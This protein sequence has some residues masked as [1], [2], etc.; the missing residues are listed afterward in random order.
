MCLNVATFGQAA[1]RGSLDIFLLH[2]RLHVVGFGHDAKGDISYVVLSMCVYMW[3]A[4]DKQFSS[5]RMSFCR[6]LFVCG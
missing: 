5:S 3:S 4:L 2:V 1:K 6:G